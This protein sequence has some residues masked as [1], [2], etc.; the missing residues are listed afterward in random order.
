MEGMGRSWVFW[1]K[2]L[3]PKSYLT[4]AKSYLVL[5]GVIPFVI[6]RTLFL[7]P[8]KKCVSEKEP[9]KVADRTYVCV[10]ESW[11]HFMPNI[12]LFSVSSL[13]LFSVTFTHFEG[14]SQPFSVSA[15]RW[16]PERLRDKGSQERSHINP[17]RRKSR[18]EFLLSFKDQF[19]DPLNFLIFPPF[20][21]L[22]S[23][24]GAF[25]AF[26]DGEWAK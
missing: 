1:G 24:P 15:S 20:S 5:P 9:E 14:T 18:T 12:E 8:S 10:I 19:V 22:F 21:F 17:I 6:Q 4:V 26:G 3:Q 2:S 11:H 25:P 16:R 23:S 13:W 7:Y